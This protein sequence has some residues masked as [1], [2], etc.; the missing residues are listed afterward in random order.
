MNLLSGF[1]ST[2]FFCS[3]TVALLLSSCTSS[4][5]E[6]AVEGPVFAID[7]SEALGE[8]PFDGRLLLMLSTEEEGEP[9]FQISD[10]PATQQVFGTDVE[11]WTAGQIRYVDAADFGY[12]V[13]SLADFPA[14]SYYVQALLHKYETFNRADGHTVKLPMDR[15]EGQQW[16]RAPGNYLS[17]VVEMSFDPASG[18]TL[19]V[20]MTREI[21]P[22]EPP[23]DTDYIKHIR[24][25]SE[26]LSEFWGR[27]M[28]LGAH[29][30]LPEGFD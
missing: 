27:D 6:E 12:P 28:Y 4:S 15:G 24:I 9:R 8:G 3:M 10:G 16:N 2:A 19:Q 22:I 25:R 17:E 23:E 14:G 1:S 13:E 29:I 11:G 26:M 5:Q 21:P 20:R 18:D 30:L 7:F